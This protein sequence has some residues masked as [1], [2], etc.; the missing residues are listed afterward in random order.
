MI[1]AVL[2]DYGDTLVEGTRP[3]D[4]IMQAA[5]E[6]AFR[7]F[8][9]NGLEMDSA[10]FAERDRE[11][12]SRYAEIEAAE[13]RDIPDLLKC[14]ELAGLVLAKLPPMKRAMVATEANVAFWNQVAG[15]YRLR[16]GAVSSL[17]RLKAMGRLMAIISNHHDGGALRRHLVALKISPYFSGVLASSELHYRKPDSRIFRL[18]AAML[19]VDPSE[20]VFVGDSP[21]ND[22]VGAKRAGM[23]TIMI[24]NSSQAPNRGGSTAAEPDYAVSDLREVP[25]IVK[26]VNHTASAC[27]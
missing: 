23:L 19:S 9:R 14:R 4:E 7:V 27:P 3:D 15:C 21:V 11:V 24:L 25:E 2:F 22:I 12:F 26:R 6:K 16:T 20:S 5:L 13:K 18:C 8:K 1:R 17:R 10:A